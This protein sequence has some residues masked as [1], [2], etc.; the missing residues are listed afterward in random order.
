MSD[1]NITCPKCGAEFALGEAVSG[2][3]REQLATEFHKERAALNAAMAER[4]NKIVAE[5]KALEEREKSVAEQVAKSLAAA[6]AKLKEAAVLEA[7]QQSEVQL[8]GLQKQ[9]DD[10]NT[11]LQA[12]R[13]E[14]LKLIN[15]KAELEDAKRNMQLEMAKQLEADRGQIAER[16]RQQAT[17]AEQLKLAD[18]DNKINELTKQIDLLQKK[19]A[20]GSMQSQ[21][22]TLELALEQQLATA[23]RYDEILEVK[24]GQRG[25]DARQVVRTNNGTVCGEILWEAKR[26]NNWS[27]DWPVKLKEDQREAQSEIGVIVTTCPPAGLRGMGLH[28]GVWVC[29]PPFAMALASALRQGIISTATQRM[30]QTDKADKMAVLYDHLCSVSFRHNVEAIVESFIG[31]KEQLE[32][33]K[34]AFARQWREREEQL[35][36]AINHTA[37]LYGGIQGIAGREALPE[38]S[39]LA[40]P[41]P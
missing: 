33:E 19:A 31:L 41:A 27:N 6:S 7:A 9:L 38:I 11:R 14:Q 8:K 35:A 18:K 23:F 37:M 21:G 25:A 5:Q 22:E 2:R 34:R 4:E 10:Q 3:L 29:E 20:Q 1:T 17:E 16:A 30:Q 13:D 36:K 40:L 12:A 39:K 26:A 28:D 32:A 15:E 24:K